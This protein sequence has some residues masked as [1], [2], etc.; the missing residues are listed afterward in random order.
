MVHGQD[1]V[2]SQDCHLRNAIDGVQQGERI[3]RNLSGNSRDHTTK[4][5]DIPDKYL[6]LEMNDLFGSTD[7][8]IDARSEAF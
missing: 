6:M 1:G 3:T 7:L 4:Y 2:S 5:S 8:V